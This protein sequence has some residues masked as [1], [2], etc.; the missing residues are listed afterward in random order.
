M[1][2]KCQKC[3]KEM[4]YY[5][6]QLKI[7]RG[8]YCSRECA[9]YGISKTLTG[10]KQSEE[11]KIKKANSN[12]GQKRSMQFRLSRSGSKCHLW[13]G[14]VW[15]NKERRN[16]IKNKR[17]RLK[18]LQNKNGSY[19]TFGEWQTLKAQYNWICPSCEKSEPEIKLTEDHII[20][21]S[22]GGSDNIENIQ[23]LCKSCNCRKQVKIIKY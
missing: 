4:T 14:G 7:G 3:G 20:P 8:K 22:K 12:R 17:N 11:T 10:R 19:H 9:N 13:K 15:Q 5:P 23:P 21:L 6:H 1:K 2:G 18:K 16:W